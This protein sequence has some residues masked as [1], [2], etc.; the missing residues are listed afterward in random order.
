MT[1]EAKIRLSLVLSKT[2][3]SKKEKFLTSLGFQVA[4][5]DTMTHS[6]LSGTEIYFAPYEAKS[7][8]S[9]G[10]VFASI[11]IDESDKLLEV[12]TTLDE[13]GFEYTAGEHHNFWEIYVVDPEGKNWQILISKREL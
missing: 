13:I 2:D 11:Q 10:S 4:E 3:Q 8:L 1:D 5:K 12:C 7:S 9:T 6:H